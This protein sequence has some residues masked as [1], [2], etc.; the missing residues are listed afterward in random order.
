MKTTLIAVGN[1]GYNIATDI[2]ESNVIQVDDVVVCDTDTQE[3]EKF[4]S[5]NPVK[6]FELSPFEGETTSDKSAM[7]A[8]VISDDMD[9]IIVCA[10]LGGKT[11]S[12][13]APLVALEGQMKN[14]VV[15]CIYTMPCIFE[16]EEVN[17][18]SEIASIQLQVSSDLFIQQSNAVIQ[19]SQYILLGEL[20]KPILATLQRMAKYPLAK[21]ANIDHDI[22]LKELPI[23]NE[24]EETNSIMMRNWYSNLNLSRRILT[25]NGANNPESLIATIEKENN[26]N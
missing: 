12:R 25:F 18:R 10:G 6:T 26:E 13:F 2:K 5:K 16:G 17:K 24:D 14:K 19:S 11:G 21:W 8:D 3:L 23:N 15:F 20:N 7:I 22:I 1:C 9:I 4:A